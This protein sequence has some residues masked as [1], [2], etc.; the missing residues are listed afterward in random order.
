MIEWK[1]G[2]D[3]KLLTGMIVLIDEVEYQALPAV[4]KGSCLGCEGADEN[5]Y[6]HDMCLKLPPCSE[7][8]EGQE[9]EIP[10]TNIVWKD[11]TDVAF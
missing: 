3:F 1:D 10:E 2:D 7:M 11:V 6:A 5:G 8:V 4:P 9:G